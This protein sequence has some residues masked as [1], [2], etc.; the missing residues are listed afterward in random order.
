ML[1]T[2]DPNFGPAGLVGRPGVGL[3]ELA[4]SPDARIVAGL[5]TALAPLD[6][7]VVVVSARPELKAEL[8][9]WGPTPG[10]SLM[11]TIKDHFDPAHRLA[12]GRFVGGI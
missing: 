12:P 9:V 3:L 2:W 11:R 10:L 4:A 1:R 7:S 6:A 8:D 5:R